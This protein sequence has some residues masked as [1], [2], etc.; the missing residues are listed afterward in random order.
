[1]V[2]MNLKYG[3]L[4]YE[5]QDT[6]SPQI[7]I[8]DISVNIDNVQVLNDKSER[9]VVNPSEIKDITLTSLDLSWDITTQLKIYRPISVSNNIR[10]E[11]DSGSLPSFRTNRSIGGGSD[12]VVTIS[13]VSNYVAR[14]SNVGGTI[15]D[16]SSVS[17]NDYVKFH[18]T[19]DYTTSP[20]S[21]SN[22]GKEFLVQAKG[23][24]YID[25]IDNGNIIEDADIVLDTN[26]DTVLK[27]LSQ[28][29]VKVGDI[30]KISGS[31]IN[32]SNT[33]EYEIVDVSDTYVEFTNPFGSDETVFYSAQ[34]FVIYKYLIGFLNIRAS[35]QL[36]MRF[37]EQQEWFSLGM[38][39]NNAIFIGSVKTYKIQIKNDGYETVTYSLQSMEVV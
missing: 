29:S 7:K 26:Y 21:D 39:K 27:V 17:A 12:T 19:D 30:L 10:V 20:F 16:L 15:W 11:Y 32:P 34:E 31:T 2:S 24:D 8:P 35:G 14:I 18:Q 3:L 1:M 13:R 25:I 28:G 22:Q 4:V 23:S 5:D 38:I 33:G 36:K 6:N 9:G 37:D